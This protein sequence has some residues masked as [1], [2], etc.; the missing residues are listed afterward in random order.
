MEALVSSG[1]ELADSRVGSLAGDVI[2]QTV[3][4]YSDTVFPRAM[5]IG[6]ILFPVA[7]GE[8]PP[9]HIHELA[10]SHLVRDA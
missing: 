9:C 2:P 7:V 1:W 5:V 6:L 8:P 4:Y 10:F 3:V